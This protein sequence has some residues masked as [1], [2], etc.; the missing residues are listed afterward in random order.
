MHR[1]L[2]LIC[3]RTAVK[4]V[5]ISLGYKSAAHFSNDFKQFYGVA[6]SQYS[7]RGAVSRLVS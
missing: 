4:S 1:A 3:D 6:P 2:E 7:T 5:A